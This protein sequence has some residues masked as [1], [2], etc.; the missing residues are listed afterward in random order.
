MPT[1]VCVLTGLNIWHITRPMFVLIG[2][3]WHVVVPIICLTMEPQ[4]RHIKNTRTE[5][6]KV[7]LFACTLW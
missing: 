5:K 7:P 3:G 4:L 1:F 6:R 2:E